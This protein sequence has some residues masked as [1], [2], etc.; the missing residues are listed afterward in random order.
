[1]AETTAVAGPGGSAESIDELIASERLREAAA[2]CHA[3]GEVD[4]AL[5]LLERAAAF[6]EAARLAVEHGRGGRGL[7]LAAVARSATLLERAAALLGPDEARALGH[8]LLVRGQPLGAAWAFRAAGAGLD[9]GE[10]WERAGEQVE[11]AQAFARVGETLRAARV[12]TARLGHEPRDGRAGLALGRILLA[13]GR[14][15]AAAKVLQG[16]PEGAAEYGSSRRLLARAFDRLGLREARN[17]LGDLGDAVAGEDDPESSLVPSVPAEG[18]LFGRYEV[19]RQAAT[20]PT[21]RVLMCRDT[22]TEKMVAVK[23][24]RAGAGG[25]EGRDAVARF[26]REAQALGLLR[27]PSIVPLLGFLPEGPAVVTPWMSGGSLADVL[28]ETQL[29]PD[30]S[31]EIALAV[32]GALGDAHRLGVLHRDV[33]PSNVLLDGAGAP[34]LADFGAAHVG[35]AATTVTAGLIGSL[36][37]LAPELLGGGRATVASDLYS[38]GAM[39][40]EALTGERPRP[41]DEVSV[42]PSAVHPELT[43]EHDRAVARLIDRSPERRPASAIDASEALRERSFRVTAPPRPRPSRVGVDAGTTQR[44]AMLDEG[45]AFDG[46]LGRRVR[47]IEATEGVK[48]RAR[49]WVSAGRDELAAVWRLDPSGQLWVEEPAGVPLSLAGRALRG[50][51][52]AGL[53]AA[54]E[55]L[56]AQGAS[57]GRVDPEH[58]WLDPERGVRLSFP[59]EDR[60]TASPASDRAALATLVSFEAR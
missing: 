18:R 60:A 36:A 58:V 24:L 33:K 23:V 11:A 32:L 31:V 7:R 2:R 35:D 39:L 37:Y 52:V 28:S 43:P 20:T 25:R 46:V 12:L 26:A 16:V 47:L 9:E 19:V 14:A 49:A 45:L 13:S 55:A 56:H 48:R 50:F 53:T 10:A 6:D 8:D 3:Q 59:H 34:Y 54:L 15:E 51:E 40:I 4:R 42:W 17:S 38:V 21:A 29:A 41:A 5:D 1:M 27:H 44:L 30:R 57:H 22:L